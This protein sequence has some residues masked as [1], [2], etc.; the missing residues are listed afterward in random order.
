MLFTELSAGAQA[1]YA[2]LL[3]ATL[4]TD[5]ARSVADLPGS[6]NLKT[7][8]GKPYYYYQYTEPSGKLRQVY[9][10]PDS[11]AVQRLVQKKALP[12]ATSALEPLARSAIALGCTPV[13]QKQFRVVRRL[14]EYGFFRAGGVLIGTHAYLA[15]GNM[16]GVRWGDASRTEDIDFAH[17]GKFV[18]LALP[19]NIEVNLGAAIDSLDMGF[20]PATGL[21]GQTESTYLIPAEP[22]FRLD[23]LT[24]LHRDGD[25]SYEHPSLKIKL[26]PLRFME[27]S[28]EAV[29]QAVLFSPS[30]AVL[31]NVPDPARFAVH[32]LLVAGERKGGFA[33]KSIKDIFQAASLMQYLCENRPDQL[34]TALDDARARGKGWASRLDEGL[35]RLAKRYPERPVR[36]LS[37]SDAR[38]PGIKPGP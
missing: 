20:L 4:V 11:E 35:S 31:V 9:V 3:D 32:K 25:K 26:Q 33:T 13:V 36:S 30:G 5:H 38:A 15:Y 19:A 10:G 16:L 28:L 2:Q 29:E 6:F 21:S 22:E 8:K 34:A 17:A 23:F 18:A 12:A 1:S 7:V 24:T 14:A 37:G 27:F